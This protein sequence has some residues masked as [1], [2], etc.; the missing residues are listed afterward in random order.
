MIKST[1]KVHEEN[2]LQSFIDD[3][4]EKK[5]LNSFKKSYEKSITGTYTKLNSTVQQAAAKTIYLGRAY[6]II[7][8]RIC[9]LVESHTFMQHVIHQLIQSST[10]T[11]PVTGPVKQ[12]TNRAVARDAKLCD[13]NIK[14]NWTMI[15]TRRYR[16]LQSSIK[17]HLQ[18]PK[19]TKRRT[20]INQAHSY[21]R[22]LS[23]RSAIPV[24]KALTSIKSI[25]TTKDAMKKNYWGQ[26]TPT[27]P[28]RWTLIRI[29]LH[30]K[31]K[32][33]TAISPRRPL[34]GRDVST[35]R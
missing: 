34:S 14:Q 23:L 12:H 30:F 7:N 1:L 22:G 16:H 21:R 32:N 18:Y 33:N 5:V 27:S 31:H 3:K 29:I 2:G 28:R 35:S 25:V 4:I 15:R 11:A 9:K 13:H 10:L 8:T 26:L 20:R 17:I 24:K 6:Y 19:M